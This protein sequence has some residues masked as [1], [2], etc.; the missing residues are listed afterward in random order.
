MKRVIISETTKQATTKTAIRHR[1]FEKAV[2]EAVKAYNDN[3]TS[4][5]GRIT[6]YRSDSDTY[7]I[8]R[9]VLED[10]SS[11]KFNTVTFRVWNRSEQTDIET[12]RGM[13]AKIESLNDDVVDNFK[14][15]IAEYDEKWY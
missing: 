10:P 5:Y 7:Y 13:G 2:D 9:Y 11:L 14:R 8:L 15:M 3:P 6:D 1:V 4:K 12:Q